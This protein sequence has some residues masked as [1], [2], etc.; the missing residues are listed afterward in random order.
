MKMDVA[1]QVAREL[2]YHLRLKIG[3][4]DVLVS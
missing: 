3:G 1:R 2:F 4:F